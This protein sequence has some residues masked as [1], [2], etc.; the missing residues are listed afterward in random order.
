[1]SRTGKSRRAGFTLPEVLVTIAIVSVLAAIIVPTVTSQITKGDET[2]FQTTIVNLRT[3]ITA[4]VKAGKYQ[5]WLAAPEPYASSGPHNPPSG[6]VGL[7]TLQSTVRTFFNAKAVESLKAGQ[8]PVQVGSVVAKEGYSSDGTLIGQALNVKV[9]SG[10][11]KDTWVFYTGF[12]GDD[13]QNPYY[14]KGHESCHE[15]HSLGTDY[16][17]SELPSGP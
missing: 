16:I 14:G 8:L 17:Q 1:M 4:F 10:S 7:R 3:G 12:V 15:C 5:G 11:G 9:E 2:R 13:Y 6:L